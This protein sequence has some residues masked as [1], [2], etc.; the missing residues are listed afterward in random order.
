MF[1][2]KPTFTSFFQ[3]SPAKGWQKITND[4]N[5]GDD[6]DGKMAIVKILIANNWLLLYRFFSITVFFNSIWVLMG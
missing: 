3:L 6:K 4:E 2:P 1:I 5:K